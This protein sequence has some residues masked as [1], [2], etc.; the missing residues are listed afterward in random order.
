[1]RRSHSSDFAGFFKKK[2]G[3]KGIS[4]GSFALL[5]SEDWL[6]GRGPHYLFSEW[7]ISGADPFKQPGDAGSAG[8]YVIIYIKCQKWFAHLIWWV[9]VQTLQDLNGSGAK[10]PS[11]SWLKWSNWAFQSFLFFCGE[12]KEM[13]MSVHHS[14]VHSAL[15]WRSLNREWRLLQLLHTAHSLAQLVQLSTALHCA[16]VGRRVEREISIFRRTS[17]ILPQCGTK[18]LLFIQSWIA[19]P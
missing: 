1:M 19:Q 15:T 8:A 10:P 2:K 6:K 7:V 18:D 16:A 5:W 14:D 12:K 3:F 17:L 4:S 11:F 9:D 13:L